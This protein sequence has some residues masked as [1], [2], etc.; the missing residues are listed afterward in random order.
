MVDRRQT[1]TK[2]TH[3]ELQIPN[4]VENGKL[5]TVPYNN[6]KIKQIARD[7]ML[8]NQEKI[9]KINSEKQKGKV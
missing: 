4:S 6:G 1:D 9:R 3:K 7:T 2:Y 5:K 8:N